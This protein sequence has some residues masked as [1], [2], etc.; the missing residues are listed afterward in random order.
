MEG[1]GKIIKSNFQR[2]IDIGVVV[3]AYN[4]LIWECETG[5]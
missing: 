1:F 3:Y 4:P 2:E 5:G